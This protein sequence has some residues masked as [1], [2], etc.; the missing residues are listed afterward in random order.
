MQGPLCCLWPSVTSCASDDVSIRPTELANL[1]QQHL[2]L[3]AEE[4]LYGVVDGAQDYALAFE[5]LKD[6]QSAIRPLFEGESAGRLNLV[7]P[8]LVPIDPNSGYLE[9]WAARWGNH[10]GILLASRVDNEMLYA[11]L[12]KIFIAEDE[13]GQEYFFRFYD[14]RVLR[15]YL[16]TCTADEAEEFFG[17]IRRIAVEGDD[18]ETLLDCTP[19]S[20]GAHIEQRRLNQS[21]GLI[22][23]V[24]KG[25]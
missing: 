14:P 15:V 13:R 16:P 10:V 23:T 7:A 17:P 5:A 11:H 21:G 19:D 18:P 12:R 24:G 8:Y 9:R 22:A 6:F 4:R 1:L 20:K 3:E 25:P 2:R